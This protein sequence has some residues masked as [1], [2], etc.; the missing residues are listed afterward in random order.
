MDNDLT[1]D[2][3]FKPCPFCGSEHISLS[4]GAIGGLNA[5]YYVECE[6]CGAC[7]PPSA[8]FPRLAEAAEV[9]EAV[10]AVWNYRR[11]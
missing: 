7:G 5:Y 8:P 2:V 1:M 9:R 11:H 10:I 3:T 4:R 6:D